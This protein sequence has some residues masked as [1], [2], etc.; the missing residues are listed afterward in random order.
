[1]PYPQSRGHLQQWA[2]I[3]RQERCFCLATLRGLGRGLLALEL[4][5][6]EEAAELVEVF[7]QEQGEE[8]PGQPPNPHSTQHT[9]VGRLN[10]VCV[11]CVCVHAQ[12]WRSG[13]FA[14]PGGDL[15][16]ISKCEISIVWAGGW[17][18]AQNV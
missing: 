2:H 3:W 6:Q 9:P 5:L 18:Q 12:G 16:Y 4:R 17:T 1:M 15:C 7:H 13:P 10:R 14:G 11:V 8:W